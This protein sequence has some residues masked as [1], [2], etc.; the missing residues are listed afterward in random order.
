MS[1]GVTMYKTLFEKIANAT[2]HD[3]ALSQITELYSRTTKTSSVGQSANL[4]LAAGV[5]AVPAY[6]M[7]EMNAREQERNKRMKYLAAGAAAGVGVP[8]LYKLISGSG[9]GADAM[10]IDAD[11]IKDLQAKAIK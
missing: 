1:A 6:L 9:D 10:G 11:Y 4:L 2:N 3:R 8:L 5:G 7:G